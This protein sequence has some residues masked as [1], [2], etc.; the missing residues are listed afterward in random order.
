MIPTHNTVFKRLSKWLPLSADFRSAVDHDDAEYIE[1]SEP[2]TRTVDSISGLL[3]NDDAPEVTSSVIE[4]DGEI[5]AWD[6][7]H[8][9]TRFAGCR[10][11]EEVTALANELCAAYPDQLSAVSGMEDAA[12]TMVAS[13]KK[14]KGDGKLPMGG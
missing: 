1:H 4:P 11:V 13:K 8:T 5:P 3:A 9:E 7:E 10:T 12:K 2:A 14:T 6:G